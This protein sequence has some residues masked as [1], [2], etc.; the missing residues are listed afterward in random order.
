M[1]GLLAGCRT[2]RETV[3]TEVRVVR[4]TLERVVVRAD[5]LVARDSVYVSDYRRGD[6]VY[7][8]EYRWR[9]RWRERWRTDTVRQV[10]RDTVRVAEKVAVKER[11]TLWERVRGWLA[12]AAV[13]ALAVGAL[14]VVRR[15]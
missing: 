12:G 5:T 11:A 3:R 7:R 15:V 1:C 13:G 14:V 10:V 6:T 9:E 8:T 4:D 2:G